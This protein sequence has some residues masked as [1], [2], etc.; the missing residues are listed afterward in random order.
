TSRPS[1]SCAASTGARC[2]RS[3][4]VSTTRWLTPGRSRPGSS[5]SREWKWSSSMSQITGREP[6]H[7]HD[8]H[9]NHRM[10]DARK[11]YGDQ[12][13]NP[14]GDWTSADERNYIRHLIRH[15]DGTDPLPDDPE[16]V[17]AIL[18]HIDVMEQTI[19]TS[20]E[21]VRELRKQHR[22]EQ[23]GVQHLRQRG[24]RDRPC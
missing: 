4:P 20:R 22:K 13:S 7:W 11:Y 15:E 5:T 23:H 9:G 24:D 19:Q 8:E 21:L 3:R 1:R 16:A 6:A 14:S 10:P 12:W 2:R 17:R 18:S